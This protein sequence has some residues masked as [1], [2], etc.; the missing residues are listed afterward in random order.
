MQNFVFIVGLAVFAANLPFFSEKVFFFFKPKQENKAFAFRF[1]ELLLLYFI[2]GLIA[3]WQEGRFSPVHQQ[4]WPFYATTF[5]LFVVFAWPGFV[6]R[7]F[8]RKPGI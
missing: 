8:W 4:N 6:W 3:Y 7:Y 2:V 1:A 5:A